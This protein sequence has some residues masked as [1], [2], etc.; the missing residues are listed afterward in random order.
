MVLKELAAVERRFWIAVVCT[1]LGAGAAARNQGRFPPARSL[2]VGQRV[3]CGSEWGG[4]D[5]GQVLNSHPVL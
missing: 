4:P 2:Q 1:V 5:A 3:W